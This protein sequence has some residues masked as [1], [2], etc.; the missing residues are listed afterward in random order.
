MLLYTAMA[1]GKMSIA[2]PVSALLAAALP[3]HRWNVHGRLSGYLT[4]LGFGFALAAIWLVSQSED[5]VKD[6]FTHF[7]DLRLPCWRVL[8]SAYTLS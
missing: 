5:G 2:A 7:S 6:I 4:L 8:A 1:Q 3:G